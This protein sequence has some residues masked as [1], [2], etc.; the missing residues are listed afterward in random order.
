[1]KL[2]YTHVKIKM[3]KDWYAKK[4]TSLIIVY[5]QDLGLLFLIYLNANLHEYV[6]IE[7]YTFFLLQVIQFV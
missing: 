5:L 2:I 4:Q 3:I 6:G 7:I 1:M